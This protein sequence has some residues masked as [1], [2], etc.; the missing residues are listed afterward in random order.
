MRFGSGTAV[1]CRR[2]EQRE[3]GWQRGGVKGKDGRCDRN[4]RALALSFRCVSSAASP[5]MRFGS[6]TAVDIGG[7]GEAKGWIKGEDGCLE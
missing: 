5:W 2:G 4:E 1:D 3:G 7:E 6:G